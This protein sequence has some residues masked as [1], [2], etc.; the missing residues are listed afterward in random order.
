M[1]DV[2]AVYI[3]TPLPNAEGHA[4]LAIE[5]R[6]QAFDRKNP[7]LDAT[8]RSTVTKAAR[9][10]NVF[11]MEAVMDAVSAFVKLFRT[12]I[13]AGEIGDAALRPS[14]W[15]QTPDPNTSV[16]LMQRAAG[17]P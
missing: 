12:T 3:A 10:A 15:P 5:M 4:L 13:Q 7:L 6:A 9:D 1:Q 11:C 16:S 2:D 17:V 14:S 8:G